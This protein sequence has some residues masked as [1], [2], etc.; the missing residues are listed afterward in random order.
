[1]EVRTGAIVAT[2]A[3]GYLGFVMVVTVGGIIALMHSSCT[4][5]KSSSD[6]AIVVV[7]RITRFS[8]ASYRSTI[9]RS[10]DLVCFVR[11]VLPLID[12]RR[13]VVIAHSTGIGVIHLCYESVM[14][15][16]RVTMLS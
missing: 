11:I 6:V 15:V 13:C 8:H 1:M 14:K 9:R 2:T 16:L 4:E 10:A 7:T 3:T 5:L 12:T